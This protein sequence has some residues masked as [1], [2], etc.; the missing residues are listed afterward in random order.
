MIVA[1]PVVNNKFWIL[2]Q[3]NVKIGEVEANS[4]GYTVKINNNTVDFKT[5]KTLK[6]ET[7]IVFEEPTAKKKAKPEHN[8]N[9]FSTNA[10]PYNAIYD[11]QKRLPLF[12]KK[13][14]SK[15]WFAAGYYQLNLDGTWVT[16]H[17]PKLIL[18]QRHE[19]RGPVYN[20]SEFTFA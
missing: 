11:V 17:C 14:E 18:L 9:G 15:S 8:V 12:T 7:R 16:L 5:I 19:Y 10:T 6:N 13:K 2:K 1:K 3:D 20:P 4:H